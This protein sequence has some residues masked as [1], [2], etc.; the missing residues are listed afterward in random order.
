ME[1]SKKELCP[2]KGGGESGHYEWNYFYSRKM[3][4][5]LK[6]KNSFYCK[7]VNEFYRDIRGWGMRWGEMS[8]SRVLPEDCSSS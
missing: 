3:L 7:C 5:L 6:E 4:K 1:D 2:Y 8:K